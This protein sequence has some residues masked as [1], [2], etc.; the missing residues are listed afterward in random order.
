MIA[1]RRKER[2]YFSNSPEYS[3]LA[4][5]MGSE[6]LGKVLSKVGNSCIHL[7]RKDNLH[8]SSFVFDDMTPHTCI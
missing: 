5:R 7:I 6:H 8:A 4:K 2:E 1:A 3:H